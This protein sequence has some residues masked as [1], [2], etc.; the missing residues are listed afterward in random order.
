MGLSANKTSCWFIFQNDRLLLTD[1]LELIDSELLS[2]LKPHLLRE[3]LIG[4]FIAR[5]GENFPRW[6]AFIYKEAKNRNCG[7]RNSKFC[8]HDKAIYWRRKY[9]SKLKLYRVVINDVLV[10]GEKFVPAKSFMEK[11]P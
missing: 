4:E 5:Q 6:T 1:T 10:K 8:T 11:Q 7:T 3:Y 2:P 9:P